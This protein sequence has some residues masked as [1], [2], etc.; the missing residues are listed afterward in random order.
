MQLIVCICTRGYDILKF[1]C[2]PYNS[3]LLHFLS[4][5]QD[6]YV[7]YTGHSLM[8]I[9]ST[10]KIIAD[11]ISNDSHL[12]WDLNWA[13]QVFL[14]SSDQKPS[15][16]CRSKVFSLNI[17]DS[18]LPMINLDI[19]LYNTFVYKCECC[20]SLGTLFTTNRICGYGH[21]QE[22]RKTVNFRSHRS[23]SITSNWYI[24]FHISGQGFY[25]RIIVH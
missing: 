20:F 2:P 21:A 8:R 11:C 9:Y 10:L 17:W 1:L 19:C 5:T 13:N 7:L 4:W 15:I 6:F 24:S 22:E 14:E 18:V 16:R 3:C 23:L 12:Q 25:Y